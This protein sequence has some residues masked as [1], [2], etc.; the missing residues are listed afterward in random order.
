M[1]HLRELGLDLRR[2]SAPGAPRIWLVL[3]TAD[4]LAAFVTASDG[5]P[6]DPDTRGAYL[7]QRYRQGAFLTWPP[8]RNGPCWCGAAC[9]VGR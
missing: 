6:E 1:A 5:H 2:L 4:S 3:G 8:P 9:T 7:D